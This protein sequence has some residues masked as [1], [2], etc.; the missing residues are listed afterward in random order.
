MRLLNLLL[1]LLFTCQI[2]KAQNSSPIAISDSTFLAFSIYNSPLP[3]NNVTKIVQA[4]NG[5]WIATWGGGITNYSANKWQTYN[6]NNSS[7]PDNDINDLLIDSSNTVWLATNLHGVVGFK[8]RTWK[9][10]DIGQSNTILCLQIDSENNIWV[11]TY[12]E[13]LFKINVAQQTVE[14]IWGGENAVRNAVHSI[15]FDQQNHVWISTNKGIFRSTNSYNKQPLKFEI[16]KTDP[17]AKKQAVH[18]AIASDTKG[19]IWSAA[20]PLG[21]IEMFNGSKWISYEESAASATPNEFKSKA[22]VDPTQQ[23]YKHAFYIDQN[24]H[25]YLGT[26]NHGSIAKF[27]GTTWSWI[28]PPTAKE[29]KFNYA[30]ITM[31]TSGTLMAGTWKHGMI[32]F[33]PSTNPIKKDAV[34]N[35]ISELIGRKVVNQFEVNCSSIAGTLLIWDQGLVDGDSISLY[36]NNQCVLPNY[37]LVAAKKEIAIELNA[38]QENKIIVYAHNLGT[39]PPNT[40]Q[41]QLNLGKLKQKYALNSNLKQCGA[42]LIH[43]E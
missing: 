18:F 33:K 22:L 9:F 31:D 29:N 20:F 37:R 6:T 35:S 23:Y 19:N 34:S 14:K 3:N 15:L 5:Y 26:Q 24:D 16:V 21:K 11:G 27:D 8:G 28:L 10:Y 7:L 38:H 32:S 39:T 25:L 36:V 4:K 1:L 40:S 42:V 2:G 17:T 41:I 13:G 30:C 12:E 43:T